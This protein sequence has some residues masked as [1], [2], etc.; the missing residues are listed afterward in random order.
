M[1]LL[2]NAEV[3]QHGLD[4]DRQLGDLHVDG[5]DL[6]IARLELYKRHLAFGMETS[7]EYDQRRNSRKTDR[8]I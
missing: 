4:G 8:I 6:T 1:Y 7:L 5:E 2:I 3:L